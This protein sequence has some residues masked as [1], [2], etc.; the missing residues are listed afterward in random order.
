MEYDN[1]EYNWQPFFDVDAALPNQVSP[2]ATTL[3]STIQ[4]LF[5][6]IDI[7]PTDVLLDIG[8]GDGRIVIRAAEKLGIHAIGIDIN[9]DL[10]SKS[11]QIAKEK[12]LDGCAYFFVK[13][14]LDPQFDWTFKLDHDLPNWKTNSGDI[15]NDDN[16]TPTIL[17]MYLLPEAIELLY[18]KLE[19]YCATMHQQN[20]KVKILS[21]FFKL[22]KWSKWFVGSSERNNVFLYVR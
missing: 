14:F 9:P 19:N 3:E 22:D 7:H 6:M 11:S 17:T 15:Y 4:T 2:F 21:I 13:N 5:S 20:K 16:I 12:S 10:V 8:S 18:P 1:E